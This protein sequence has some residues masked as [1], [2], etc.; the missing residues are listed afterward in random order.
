MALIR[1][2]DL[3]WSAIDD[4]NMSVRRKQLG[5][6]AGGEKLGCSLYELP[7]G[8]QSWPYHYHTANEE[9]IYV[10]SGHGKLRLAG[11]IYALSEGAY[12]ALP[13]DKA[14][15]HTV[16]N[17]TDEPLRYLVFSTMNDP[18]VTVYPDSDKIGVYV[19]SPPGGRGDRSIHGYYAIDDTVDYWADE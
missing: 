17:D 16:F 12:A 8:E 6:A 14:G 19:G 18:D 9:A 2:E 7:P 15:G 3:E 1:A 11:E 13:A 10:L 4:G 5:D